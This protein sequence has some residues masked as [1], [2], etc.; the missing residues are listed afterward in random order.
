[1]NLNV[2]VN[3]K[4]IIAMKL[5]YCEAGRI[6]NQKLFFNYEQKLYLVA[7]VLIVWLGQVVTHALYAVL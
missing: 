6:Y 3:D 7:Y 2:V 4:C 5:L 1:M